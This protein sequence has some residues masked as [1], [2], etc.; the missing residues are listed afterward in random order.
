MRSVL[1]VLL[2]ATA[3]AACE[4]PV[5]QQ[6]RVDARM[7]PAEADKI[8]AI[9]FRP[10]TGQLA[11]NQV[12]E[13]RA[14]VADNRAA[15]RDEFVVVTDGSGGPVQQARARQIMSSLSTA[16]ARW[17]GSAVEPAMVMGPDKVVVVRSEYRVAERDCPDY[18]P[19][20]IANT[21]EATM[22]G[23][24]CAN[25]YNFGQM[26]ARSRDA[27]VGRSPGP[28]DATVNAA[29]IQRYREG[30]VRTANADGSTGGGGTGGTG[31]TVTTSGN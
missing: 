13:L 21:N 24:G 16:G 2:A 10:G 4:D 15:E 7:K 8:L 29:A 12:H 28:A 25:A 9:G 18:V 22:P 31:V 14:L 11:P 30:K 26:L 20:S 27:A 19:A 23:F 17:V 3:L 5:A 6:A 1:L